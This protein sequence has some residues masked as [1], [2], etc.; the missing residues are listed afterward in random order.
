MHFSQRKDSKCVTRK[1]HWKCTKKY[2]KFFHFVDTN[3]YDNSILLFHFFVIW[4]SV[5][6]KDFLIISNLSEIV[7][8]FILL[9]EDK[10][11]VQHESAT[12]LLCTNTF[13]WKFF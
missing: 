5:E 9:Y 3:V 1:V 12:C 10:I 7:C 6:Y 8:V 13:V 2:K 11:N 4:S